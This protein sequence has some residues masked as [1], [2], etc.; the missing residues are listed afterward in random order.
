MKGTTGGVSNVSS[1][2][3]AGARTPPHHRLLS[4]P[5]TAAS[6]VTGAS[7]VAPSSSSDNSQRHSHPLWR[8]RQEVE[9]GA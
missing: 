2:S 9:G 4:L 3:H 7:R 5:G 1:P 8:P 6:A